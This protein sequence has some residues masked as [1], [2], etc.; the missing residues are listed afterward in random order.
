MRD[1]RPRSHGRIS[2]YLAVI[3]SL[4]VLV[5]AGGFA[6]AK[7]RAWLEDTFAPPAD[8]AGP[9]EGRVLIEV[10][11]G[12]TS[13]QIAQTL[14]EADVVASVEAFMDEARTEEMAALIQAGFYQMRHK[15]SA[16][17]ALDVLI[18]HDN[19]VQNAVTIPEGFTVDQT[20]KR[21]AKETDIPLRRL[22][23][24]ADH[25]GKLG[26]PAY[27]EGH[28]EGFL[29][30]ATYPLPPDATARGVLTT[31]VDR[32]ERAAEANDLKQRA[33]ALGITP[34]EAVTVASI[35]EAEA[36]RDEDVAK[37]ARVIYNRLEEGMRLQMDSTV[38]YAVG[39][40]GNVTTTDTDRAIDSPYNTYRV[41]GLPPAPI[42][43]PGERA[44]SA[45]L[46]PAPGD[47]LFF[48]TV[49]LRT[50]ETKFAE[51]GE[52]HARNVEEFREYCR[53]SDAC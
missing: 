21:I 39:K 35:V 52:Q 26:L 5:G 9:G 13:T 10:E 49:N 32:F 25:P 41:H 30:P 11:S 29:F 34:L 14:E 17:A 40:S 1:N 45:A 53:S 38:H 20:L 46:H 51:T 24:A 23:A 47:W 44:L 7:G 42:D 48:V 15:M 18:D 27:A 33:K 6:Y 22:K 8:Y 28:L 43:S 37:V 50:G 16:R 36:R 31:M 4:A 12:Q 3:V 19:L 2:G